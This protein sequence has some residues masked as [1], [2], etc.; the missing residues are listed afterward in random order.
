MSYSKRSI[1]FINQD[2]PNQWQMFREI[3]E[4]NDIDEQKYGVSFEY[5]TPQ[6]NKDST[7]RVRKKGKTYKGYITTRG[8]FV[9]RTYKDYNG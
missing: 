3:D 7:F 6:W 1:L 4:G 9:V 8:L 2:L 5:L